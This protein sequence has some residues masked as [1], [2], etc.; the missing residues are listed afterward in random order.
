LSDAGALWIR[1]R[2]NICDD[3]RH[4]LINKGIP[5]P[6]EH[7]I[8]DYGLYLLD[9]ILHGSAKSL[10][11]FPPMPQPVEDWIQL[12]ENRLIAEQLAYNREEQRNLAEP[13]IQ[14]LNVEQ[15]TAFDAI[16]HSVQNND[17][18]L[19]FLN[20][21]GG[22]GKTHVYNTLCYALRAEG[23]IVLCVAS[24][25]IAALLLLGGRTSHSTFKIPIA[26]WEGR[27]CSIKKG[28]MLAELLKKVRLIIWDEV[29]MQDRRAQEAVDKTMQDIRDDPRPYGGTT[30]VFGGDFQQILP[31]VVKGG[32]EDIVGFCLQ[33]S[34]LWQ[35]VHQLHLTQNMRLG[36]PNAR[37]EDRDFA[38]W[39]LDVGH[40][41]NIDPAQNITLPEIMKLP[42]NNVPSLINTIY[43]GISTIPSNHDVD[44]Y[45][46]ERTI[47]SARNDDVDD[48]N[49]KLLDKFI[50]E[51]TIFHSADSV[52]KEQGVDSNFEYP[53]E[54]LN[55]IRASGL[56]LS[57]LAL[58]VGCPIMV[59][60]NLDP[61]QG[62]CN[63]SRGILTKMSQYVLEIRL[64]GGEH[65]GKKAFIP[66]IT[67]SPSAE[68]IAFE[69]KRRQFPVRLAFAMTINKSQ[70][71]S[72][73]NI[74]LDL[75]TDVFAHGQLY[76]ALSRCTSSQRVK[77]LFKNDISTATKNIVY[78]E[79]LL[80]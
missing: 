35:K 11:D 33:R 47:L 78:P 13:R 45:F 22:T 71:Q 58:K 63:G 61:A 53:I 10:A 59:L 46:L 57:K 27:L 76:V 52:V 55:S 25:G 16:M 20:G 14:G 74:G 4:K 66:R 8:Y 77:A 28:T 40:G 31:V 38:K 19:F 23:I 60:R 5:N 49:Q 6:S 56:P 3:V 68:Q 41:R 43:P 48:L 72:V 54:Y 39:L 2:D 70:G 21:P 30:V 42:E 79:V 7:Q 62:L 18:K 75:R 36:G 50:G 34:L 44:K 26:L 73:D 80:D 69:M 32:R 9:S 17:P 15:R 51:Q 24:S 1:F 12:E 37:Q 29:P 65:A 64:I 67:I